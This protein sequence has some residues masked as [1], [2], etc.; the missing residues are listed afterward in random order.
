M[1]ALKNKQTFNYQYIFGLFFRKNNF[2]AMRCNGNV[3]K[4][5][6]KIAKIKKKSHLMLKTLGKGSIFEIIIS[7]NFYELAQN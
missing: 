7:G 2:T 3:P 1:H 4:S 5:K 6:Y